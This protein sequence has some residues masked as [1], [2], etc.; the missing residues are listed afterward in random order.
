MLIPAAT[1]GRVQQTSSVAEDEADA[2]FDL[3]GWIRDQFAFLADHGFVVDRVT[4]H[5]LQWRKGSRTIELSSDWR[6]GSLDLRFAGETGQSGRKMFNLREA[7]QLV[8]PE[9]WPSHGWAA[10]RMSTAKKYVAELAALV[11]DH[12]GAFL[13]DGD[14][15][16]QRAEDRA[17]DRATAGGTGIQVDQL[18]RQANAARQVRDWPAVIRSYEEL[19]AIGAPLTPSE[20]RR[21]QYARQHS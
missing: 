3:E 10:G 7:L 21:L 14:E 8:A 17:R 6:D 11:S 18:R 15:L 9:A 20:I 5:T 2:G 1:T 13:G 4:Q 12:L 19:Q 16:W